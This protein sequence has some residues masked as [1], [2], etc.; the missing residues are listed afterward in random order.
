MSIKEYARKM[1][2]LANAGGA[3][4]DYYIHLIK[5][6]GLYYRYIEPNNTK[7]RPSVNDLAKKLTI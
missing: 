2:E 7:N 6:F 5:G 1:I 4:S 3:N